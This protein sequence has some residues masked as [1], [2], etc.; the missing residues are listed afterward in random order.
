[1]FSPPKRATIA[2]AAS[3]LAVC[4]SL[5]QTADG[6]DAEF[7]RRLAAMQQARARSTQPTTMTEAP[8]VQV[9]QQSQPVRRVAAQM[10]KPTTSTA[11]Q[12]VAQAG[13]RVASRS[14]VRGRFVPRHARTAQ[15]MDGSII[16]GGAPIIGNESMIGSSTMNGTMMSNSPIID[17]QVVAQPFVETGVML[18]GCADGGCGDCSSCGE[19]GGYFDDCCGRGGCP[20][21]QPCW[22]NGFGAALRGAEFYSGFTSFRSSLFTDPSTASND[23]VDDCSHGYYGGVNV[24][25][26]LCRLTCGVFSG[27]FGV[28]TV[29]TN[30]NG[31]A[32]TTDDRNQLFFTA[33]LYRRVDYGIQ[34]GVVAD[35]LREEWYANSDLVQIRGD[36]GYVWPA[37]TTFGF[38]FATNVQ[39]DIVAGTFNGQAFTNQ[40]VTTDDNYRFYLRH[41]AKPGGWGEI[42]AGWSNSNQGII[43]LDFDMPLTNRIGFEAGFTYYLNDDEVPANR[44]LLGGYSGQAYNTY[45]GLS[46]RP[47]GRAGYRSYD[48]PLLD[49]ADNGSMLM[50]RN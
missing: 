12:A 19:V 26:P 36:I 23:L 9:A 44:G 28:R 18:N 1:M 46:F 14:R 41:D 45:I 50:I 49:V 38:R 47:A 48:R 3:I 29:N 42:F 22:L 13:A 10:T 39:D 37:G 30:F 35:V 20:E 4:L 34:F 43:G 16:D 27:Q 24:G 5:V 31:S 40:G 11:T 21:G 7:N 6:Q 33:G 15:V 32:F 17:G 25:I 2:M 8:P